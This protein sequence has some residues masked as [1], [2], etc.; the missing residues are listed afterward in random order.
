MAIMTNA[1]RSSTTRG[2]V[3]DATIE[4]L[5]KY[6]YHG[7]TSTRIAEISG[8]TRGAQMHH[9]KTK[10]GLVVAALL[11]IHAKRIEAFQ[12]MAETGG[13]RSLEALIEQLWAS[14]NDDVWLAASEL[15]TAARTDAELRVE[16]V[17]AERTINKRIRDHLTP[18]LAQSHA[19]FGL[20]DLPPRRITAIVGLI[21]SVM[22]G[23]AL[24]EAFDPDEKR[25]KAQRVE[26]VR[27]LTALLDVERQK[28]ESSRKRRTGHNG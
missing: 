19:G 14:F 3:L 2:A 16:L 15:W 17:P 6:G 22:R 20:E 13:P 24:Y 23:M 7:A 10:A 25:A 1:E 21:N 8:L 11:H 26:L 18:I 5:V 12:L 28:H 27:A 4:A 9:F